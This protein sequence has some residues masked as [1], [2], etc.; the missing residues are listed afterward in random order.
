MRDCSGW[1][2]AAT[3]N[4]ST[5]ARSVNGGRL[6]LLQIRGTE[7]ILGEPLKF[8]K[9]NIDQFDFSERVSA[10]SANDR[11]VRR[12]RRRCELISQSSGSCRK[13]S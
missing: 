4:A 6:G 7:I 1:L 13:S 2:A 10:C 12:R 9:A 11:E 8:M 5:G 3:G